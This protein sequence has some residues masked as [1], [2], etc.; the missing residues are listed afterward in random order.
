MTFETTA[1]LF[2]YMQQLCSE[3]NPTSTTRTTMLALL[4]Q[5][6]KEVI[7]GGG[8]LNS[9][10]SG[11][12][13]TAAAQWDWLP[14]TEEII[15]LA[16]LEKY[17]VTVTGGSAAATLSA[18]PGS[19]RVDWLIMFDSSIYRITANTGTSITLDSPCAS[20]TGSYAAQVYKLTHDLAT[21][22]VVRLLDDPFRVSPSPQQIGVVTDDKI[23]DTW[24]YR[25]PSNSLI[26]QVAFRVNAE[27]DATIKLSSVSDRPQRLKLTML[28]L[29]EELDLVGSDPILPRQ[30][31]KM[32]AHLASYYH[33]VKRDDNKAVAC[34][35]NARTLFGLMNKEQMAKLTQQGKYEFARAR[36]PKSLTRSGTSRN[37]LRGRR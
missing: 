18:A 7:S 26:Q 8:L 5:A 31:R 37:W 23:T 28:V 33:L 2:E 6:H 21:T 4:D 35:N 29:P 1:D 13:R 32:L 17:S 11:D 22:D 9:S 30:H 10:Q 15:Y 27:G 34:L 12:P 3:R 25:T 36:L 19:S 24:M 16:P 14:R 20:N